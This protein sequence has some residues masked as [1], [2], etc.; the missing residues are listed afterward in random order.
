MA[1]LSIALAL[2]ATAHAFT[3]PLA[4]RA[5]HK[6]ALV[7]P[8]QKGVRNWLLKPQTY[9]DCAMMSLAFYVA[10]NVFRTEYRRPDLEGADAPQQVLQSA[11]RLTRTASSQ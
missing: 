8:Q 3:G 10:I 2:L 7:A 11:W 9:Y 5:P 6:N 1:R 4:P